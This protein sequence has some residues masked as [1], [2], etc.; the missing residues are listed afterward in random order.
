MTS[1]P[2]FGAFVSTHEHQSRQTTS[3]RRSALMRATGCTGPGPAQ[4][5][6][7]ELRLGGTPLSLFLLCYLDTPKT[8]QP[9]K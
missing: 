6:S 8:G 5:K 7:L 1:S 9:P 4:A 2:V 3:H